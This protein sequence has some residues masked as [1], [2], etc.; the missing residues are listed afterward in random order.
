MSIPGDAAV[1]ADAGL[2]DVISMHTDLPPLSANFNSSRYG[3]PF[4]GAVGMHLAHALTISCDGL[5]STAGNCEPI[6]IAAETLPAGQPYAEVG[7]AQCST[8]DAQTIDI[9]QIRGGKT[10]AVTSAS[11]PPHTINE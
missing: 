1:H 6:V 3:V 7:H 5:P 8:Q 2:S 4:V 10:A 9:A 11:R